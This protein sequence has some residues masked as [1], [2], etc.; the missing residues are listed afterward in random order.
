MGNDICRTCPAIF[1]CKTSEFRLFDFGNLEF[2]NPARIVQYGTY[3]R[4]GQCTTGLNESMTPT[5]P[6]P[7]SS[8]IL[9]IVVGRYWWFNG[10]SA[11][12]MQFRFLPF[13]FV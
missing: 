1:I 3:G 2:G 6:V 8:E 11:E 12:I 13:R 4:V 9:V 7:Y 5:L 10:A